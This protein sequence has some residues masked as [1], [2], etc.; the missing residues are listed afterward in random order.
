LLTGWT[1]EHTRHFELSWAHRNIP[2]AKVM[3]PESKHPKNWSKFSRKG[4]EGIIIVVI[5]GFD[6]PGK[7][8]SNASCM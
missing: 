5:I 4:V 3:S 6:G 2:V 1:N 8:K 7:S